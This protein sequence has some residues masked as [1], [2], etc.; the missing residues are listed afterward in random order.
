MAYLRGRTDRWGGG[1]AEG[2][3]VIFE[4]GKRYYLVIPCSL[5]KT[6]KIP[7]KKII[8]TFFLETFQLYFFFRLEL[9][10]SIKNDIFISS[11]KFY[12]YILYV[13]IYT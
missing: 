8:S 5:K 12:Y 2:G 6:I 3:G 10:L 11:T 1:G 7:Q 13:S 4:I 9:N